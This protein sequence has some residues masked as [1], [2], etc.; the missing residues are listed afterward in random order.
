MNKKNKSK[1]KT[2]TSTIRNPRKSH[3]S[4][5]TSPAEREAADVLVEIGAEPNVA[6]FMV[7]DG[8]DRITKIQ[9]LT[10]ETIALYARNIRKK[11]LRS[12]IV[13]TR[14]ILDLEQAA[15]KMT[16]ITHR[17][18]YAIITTNID[19]TWCRSMND[20]FDLEQGW[21]NNPLKDLYPT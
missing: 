4:G 3:C 10:R 12:D 18:S 5:R 11:T 15:I 20:K 13:R 21:K 1:R 6:K 17:V 14:F 7:M 2:P 19:R 8:L 9:E 16:H